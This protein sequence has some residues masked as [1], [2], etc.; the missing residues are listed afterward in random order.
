MLLHY[1]N[2]GHFLPARRRGWFVL[3]KIELI[4]INIIYDNVT[5]CS[6]RAGQ[7]QGSFRLRHKDF[8]SVSGL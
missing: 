8:V 1:L 7:L 3:D 5:E 4:F 2:L 6:A